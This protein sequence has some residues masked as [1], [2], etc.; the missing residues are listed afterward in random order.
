[1]HE[2][3]RSILRSFAFEKVSYK[4]RFGLRFSCVVLC[5]RDL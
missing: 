4:C 5:F 1:M 2:F 3:D